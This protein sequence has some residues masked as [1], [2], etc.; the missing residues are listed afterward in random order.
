MEINFLCGETKINLAIN[1]MAKRKK[2]AWVKKLIYECQKAPIT[3]DGI[4]NL[5]GILDENLKFSIEKSIDAANPK[6]FFYIITCKIGGKK[7]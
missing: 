7:I 6:N 1:R 2:I 3:D 5:F 4:I